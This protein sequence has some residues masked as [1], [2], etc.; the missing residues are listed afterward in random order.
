MK[1]LTLEYRFLQKINFE[2]LGCPGL[3][4]ETAQLKAENSNH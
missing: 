3:E 4:P 1:Y 2:Y